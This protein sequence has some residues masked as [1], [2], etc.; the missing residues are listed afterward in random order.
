MSKK[1]TL[2]EAQIAQVEA[3]AAYLPIDKIATA[4]KLRK[5]EFKKKI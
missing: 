2:D 4:I 5:R 1:I 3:L